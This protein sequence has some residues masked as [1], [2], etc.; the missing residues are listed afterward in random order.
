MPVCQSLATFL[1]AI[2]LVHRR[3][4]FD[5]TAM[6]KFIAR[7]IEPTA[8]ETERSVEEEHPPHTPTHIPTPRLTIAS[9]SL[10]AVESLLQDKPSAAG[11]LGSGGGSSNL[12]SLSLPAVAGRLQVKPSAAECGGV[13][14]AALTCQAHR[15]PR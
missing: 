10:P 15:Y 9:T 1:T 4:K 5:A 2:S 8:G 13:G 7:G 12:P 14:A 6:A 11:S 3:E